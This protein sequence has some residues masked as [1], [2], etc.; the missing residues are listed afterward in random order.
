MLDGQ[1]KPWITN[2]M[3]GWQQLP[4]WQSTHLLPQ[5]LFAY[6]LS[7]VTYRDRIKPVNH[8][9][10]FRDKRFY[11]DTLWID[12]TEY[13]FDRTVLATGVHALKNYQ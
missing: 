1:Y 10:E 7:Q 9:K 8:P 2:G 3:R 12:R 11:S 6:T 4:Q 5:D 13:M